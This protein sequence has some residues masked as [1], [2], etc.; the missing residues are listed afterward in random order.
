MSRCK[1][2]QNEMM[3][4][5]SL[6]NISKH[7]IYLHE[8]VTSH[9]LLIDRILATLD[10]RGMD[11]KLI[12]GSEP[13][14]TDS[15]AAAMTSTALA[16]HRDRQSLEYRKTLFKSTQLRLSSL[17]NRI[18]NM[19]SLSFNLVTQQDSMS[20]LRGSTHMARDSN[21]MKIISGITML[22]L[23]ATAVASILGSQVFQDNAPTPLFYIMLWITVPLTIIVFVSVHLWK[24]WTERK[25]GGGHGFGV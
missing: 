4:F 5:T 12:D 11:A 18:D 23:P 7:A 17:R 21:S 8:G 14:V 6:H 16:R 22:F 19:L 3:P 2:R 25:L 13:K 24:R 15:S 9:L 20:M 10:E 1:R